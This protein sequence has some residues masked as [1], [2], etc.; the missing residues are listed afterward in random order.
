MRTRG[1][2]VERRDLPPELQGS[3]VA[4]SVPLQLDTDE[5]TRIR[6]AL[7]QADGNRSRAARLLGISRATLYRRL[8]ELG[9]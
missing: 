7:A 6:A 1:T 5:R 4:S 3:T 9:I 2:W 8:S